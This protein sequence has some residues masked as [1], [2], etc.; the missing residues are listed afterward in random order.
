M[1]NG[2]PPVQGTAA[3]SP[4]QPAPIAVP[5]QPA[6]AGSTPYDVPDLP[7][8]EV[9]DALD[10]AGRVLNELDR[11]QVSISLEHDP[12]TN[13]ITARV[14]SADGT[15]TQLSAGALLNVLSGDTAALGLHA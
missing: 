4:L 11:K 9:L 1:V 3:G 10:T 5:A 13:A 2:L 12:R 15:K 8:A 7:P 14:S 6:A